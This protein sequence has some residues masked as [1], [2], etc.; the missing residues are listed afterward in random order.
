M[1]KSLRGVR[2]VLKMGQN[3]PKGVPYD[4]IMALTR[5]EVTDNAVERDT[6]QMSFTAGKRKPKDYGILSTGLF[7]PYK[8]VGISLTICTKV[9]TLMSCVITRLHIDPHKHDRR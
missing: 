4:V 8:R 9:E 7:K 6:F 1:L 2:L 5:I 3:Q